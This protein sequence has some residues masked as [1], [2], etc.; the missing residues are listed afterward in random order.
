MKAAV[1]REFKQPL[2][3]ER[4]DLAE[5]RAGE[6]RVRIAACAICHSDLLFMDG[7]WGGDLPAVFGHEAAGIVE[8][9]GAEVEQVVPGDHVVVTLLR[10]CGHCH[11]CAQGEP[12]LCETKLPLD[13]RSP[14]SASDGST[15]RQGLRT[16][17]FAEQVVVHASQ[18]AL[19]PREVPLESASLLA[20][21]VITG[22]GAV[23]NTAA[24]RAG[25]HVATIGTGGVGLNCVQ[26]AAIGGASVNIAIDVSDSKLAAARTFGATHTIDPREGSARD[27]VR[28]LTG[29]RGADYVFVAAGSAVAIE[30]GATLLRRGGTLVVVGMTADG[31]KV[32]LEALD[33]ADNALRILG[34]KMGS[35]RLPIDIPI[36]VEWY[37]QGRLRLDELI[38][39]RYPLDQ[40]NEAIQSARS[41]AALR[42]VITF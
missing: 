37:R 28:D 26:G 22:L 34:S 20:C 5:P 15:I 11:F 33:I 40:I 38:S 3:I 4:V 31:V 19:I 16:G 12:Q 24:M 36:L 29:G 7:A 18:V 8:E 9:V 2:S 32:R 13:L 23:L 21:G 10:A 41:G 35:A 17:A 30:E 14:L 39:G 27:A 1:C 25:G 42:N 6:V